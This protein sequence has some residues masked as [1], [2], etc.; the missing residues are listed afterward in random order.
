MTKTVFRTKEAS[1]YLAERGL[2]R[3][4]SLL[5]K[6]RTRKDGDGRDRGPDFYRENNKCLYPKIHLDSYLEQQL[7]AYTFRGT[8][9]QPQ[10]FRKN[11]LEVTPL[12][13]G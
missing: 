3:S 13:G 7:S 4:P 8:V 11:D 12:C 2:L 6:F 10:N 5:E 9:V 1:N